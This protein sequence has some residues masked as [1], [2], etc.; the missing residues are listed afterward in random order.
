MK[1]KAVILASGSGTRLGGK[2]YPKHLTKLNGVEILIWLLKN[3]FSYFLFD[4]IFVV[5]RKFDLQLTKEV[6]ENYYLNENPLKINFLEGGEK[7]IDSISAGIQAIID[8]KEIDKKQ[9]ISL[10]DAN[11]PFIDKTQINELSN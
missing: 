3:L 1:G 11:R 6:V 2:K 8:N 9:I 4:E 5:C 10:F 7:R